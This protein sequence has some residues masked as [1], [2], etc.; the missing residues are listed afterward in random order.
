MLNNSF[1]MHLLK[2]FSKFLEKSYLKTSTGCCSIWD[3][4]LKFHTLI[5]RIIIIST[6]LES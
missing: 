5:K 2:P 6:A 1:L 4:S 3:K